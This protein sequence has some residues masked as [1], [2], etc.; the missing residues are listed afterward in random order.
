MIS[1]RFHRIPLRHVTTI[2]R[3]LKASARAS[4]SDETENTYLS[5]LGALNAPVAIND[6]MIDDAARAIAKAA[7]SDCFS[8]IEE[9]S[10]N[11]NNDDLETLENKA[12]EPLK[13]CTEFTLQA[14]AALE[15]TFS[16]ESV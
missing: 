14:K 7:G 1:M 8:I 10:K 2:Q 12:L 11:E 16:T 4:H 5:A 3:S 13:E 15:A 9:L 6:K